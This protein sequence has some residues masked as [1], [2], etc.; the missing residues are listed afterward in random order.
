MKILQNSTEPIYKQVYC[1][2]R[3]TRG[4]KET[5]PLVLQFNMKRLD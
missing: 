3:E 4:T 2:F 1:F 5:F